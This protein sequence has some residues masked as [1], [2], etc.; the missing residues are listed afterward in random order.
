MKLNFFVLLSV[1]LISSCTIENEVPKKQNPT[2]VNELG[3]FINDWTYSVYPKSVDNFST[4]EFKLWVPDVD[5]LNGVLVLSG[6]SNS[7]SLFLTEDV[8]WRYFATSHRLAIAA[9]H[10]VSSA[11]GHYGFA[12]EGSGN[13]LILAINKIAEKNNISNFDKLPYFLRGYSAGG[14]FSYSFSEFFPGKTAAVVDIRGGIESNN[15]NNTNNLNIPGLILVGEQELERIESVKSIIANKRSRKGLWSY[16]I[17]PNAHHSSNQEPSDNLARM[18]FTKVLTNRSE[19]IIPDKN[20]IEKGFLGNNLT[21]EYQ[22]YLEYKEAIE[23]ASWL[24][25][26]T[27]AQE[28]KNYQN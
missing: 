7:N 22:P 24:I 10:M 9:T 21:L 16:A 15:T 2:T 20:F 17:E 6:H 11:S 3:I 13:A 5:E 27:F 25:D 12:G 28:W 19:I 1:F 26:A 23:E 4:A 18:F 8:K 14:I